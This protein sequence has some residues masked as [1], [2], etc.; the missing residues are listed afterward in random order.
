MLAYLDAAAFW[1]EYQNTIEY[2]F[3]IWDVA[4][5]PASFAGFKFLNTGASRVIGIDISFVGTAKFS[6]NFE[7]TFLTGYN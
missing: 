6:K 4:N 5:A 2:M 7:L 1:Q 3:G